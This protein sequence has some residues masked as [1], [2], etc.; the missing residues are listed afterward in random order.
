MK[1]SKASDPSQSGDAVDHVGSGWKW[2]EMVGNGQKL[3]AVEDSG[4][5]W[6]EVVWGK[7]RIYRFLSIEKTKLFFSFFSIK[8][9][10][11]KSINQD[12]KKVHFL[13]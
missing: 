7:L 13:P 6:L 11:I 12:F 4:W 8:T 9:G 5:T 1:I 10:S 2:S 3:V